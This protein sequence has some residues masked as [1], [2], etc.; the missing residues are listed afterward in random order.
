MNSHEHLQ[1]LVT[2]S[3]TLTAEYGR[4]FSHAELARMVQF[5]QSFPD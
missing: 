2:A 4:G 3:R 1:I 5:A